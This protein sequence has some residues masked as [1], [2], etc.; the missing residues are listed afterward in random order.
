MAST[1][2][3]PRAASINDR[4]ASLAMKQQTRPTSTP[5]SSLLTKKTTT[6]TVDTTRAR[7][8]EHAA[9]LRRNRVTMGP[10][11]NGDRDSFHESVNQIPEPKTSPS[12]EP[13]WQPTATLLS[14]A[15]TQAPLA[16]RVSIPPQAKHAPIALQGP[17]L[18]SLDLHKQEKA[19]IDDLLFVLLGLEGQYITFGINREPYD[20]FDERSRLAGPVFTIARGLDPSLRDLTQQVLKTATCTSAL[21][22]F[23]E[24]MS[25]YEKGSVSHALCAAI[26]KIQKDFQI[27]V[28]QLEHQYLTNE[29]FSLHQLSLHLK[30]SVHVMNLLFSL[31]QE[32]L[33]QNGL[34]GNTEEDESSNDE[35]D[36]ENVLAAING[37][38][39]ERGKKSCIGG[40]LLTLL[41]K[42]LQSLAGDPQA[43]EVLTSLLAE[44]SK[45]YIRMLNEWLHHGNVKDP[46]FEFMIK[47]AKSIKREGLEQDYTD[48]YWEKRY[49]I[50]QEHVPQQLAGVVERCL[51]AGKYLNVVRECS[52]GESLMVNF[53]NNLSALK[54]MPQDI[55]DPNLLLSVNSAYHHANAALMR[56][57]L[58]THQLPQRLKSLKHYFFLDRSDWFTYFLEL[59]HSE[60]RKHAKQSNAGKL[61]SLLDLVLHTPGSVAAE[62]PFK[63]DIRVILNDTALTGYLMRIVN[64]QGMDAEAT[65][66]NNSYNPAA[67]SVSGKEDDDLRVH[68]VLTLDTSV[69]FPLSLIISRVTLTRYQFLFRYLLSLKYL[70]HQLIA[71]W[72]EA[73]G[74]GSVVKSSSI[75]YKEANAWRRS[76]GGARIELWKRRAWCLRS[77]MLT[78]VQQLLYFCTAEV[79]DPAWKSFMAR[80][81]GSLQDKSEDKTG[82]EAPGTTST[83]AAADPKRTADELMQDHVDFLATCLKEC[84]L[85]NSKLLRINSKVTSTCA[86]FATYTAS[87]TRSLDRIAPV[88]ATQHF[89]RH[90]KI[91][92]DALNYLAATETLK[93]VQTRSL[94]LRQST[95]ADTITM[96]LRV[97]IANVEVIRSHDIVACTDNLATWFSMINMAWHCPRSVLQS[98]ASSTSAKLAF[99]D[100]HHRPPHQK[101][102]LLSH[103]S[104]IEYHKTSSRLPVSF[105]GHYSQQ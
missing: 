93:V 77:R 47:E 5:E 12:M 73:G 64:T 99:T 89:S 66:L 40:A 71:S 56:L 50:R 75:S 1:S 38:A 69:P 52:R 13:A 91:L 81:T 84:M 55:F 46:H 8:T 28:A 6:T 31:T 79:I 54:G 100:R 68:Q 20:P 105:E 90:L 62:D 61:Q 88:G 24:V 34:L 101:T 65:S 10:G 78:F 57:L 60:L 18:A 37:G 48:D 25:R 7:S 49:T 76:N 19:M 39:S 3:A 92:L 22:A 63:E 97:R 96:A 53:D 85:T 83:D 58:T 27:L 11:A 44:A 4:R 45:P 23:V 15:V 43:K 98:N 86:H 74:I 26:R 82:D 94:F 51:L 32:I 21:D 2:R 103:H 95:E 42:R 72:A 41:I 67:D 14:I 16:C 36:F 29:N 80:V 102:P 87:F 30:K 104:S 59:S 9:V 33:V 35:D 17:N 70:E